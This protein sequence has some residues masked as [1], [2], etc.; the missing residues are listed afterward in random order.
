MDAQKDK[1]RKSKDA[2][3]LMISVLA[4]EAEVESEN[5]HTQTMAGREQKAKESKWNG[6]FAPQIL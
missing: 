4:A 6:G 2:G 3:K 5:V 1:L